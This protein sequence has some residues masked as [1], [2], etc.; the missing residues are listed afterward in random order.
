MHLFNPSSIYQKLS[1]VYK[2]LYN[3]FLF[4]PPKNIIAKNNITIC[5]V[6]SEH[7]VQV[8]LIEVIVYVHTLSFF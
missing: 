1:H 3:P 6:T 5:I 2:V 4:L 7:I 8:P